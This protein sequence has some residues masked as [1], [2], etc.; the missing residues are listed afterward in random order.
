M[1]CLILGHGSSNN[2]EALDK[3]DLSSYSKVFTCN[4]DCGLI[5]RDFHKFTVIIG[6]IA[7]HDVNRARHFSNLG[8]QV[9]HPCYSND[10][11]IGCEA[12]LE[13][14]VFYSSKIYSGLSAVQIALLMGYKEIHVLGCDYSY[15]N[16]SQ[17]LA[18]KR[19]YNELYRH[20]SFTLINLS[21]N[22]IGTHPYNIGVGAFNGDIKQKLDMIWTRLDKIEDLLI[23]N[24]NL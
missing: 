24:F 21:G 2:P 8:Y 4:D 5:K 12:V 6:D 14:D 18:V 11:M 19:G 16:E 17:L 9:I 23:K 22:E 7:S 15:C 1:A 3:L 20:Y 10:F 13:M